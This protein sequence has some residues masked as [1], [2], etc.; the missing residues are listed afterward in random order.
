MAE[1]D[2]YSG[3]YT[4]LPN[5]YNS[6]PEPHTA[7]PP[8]PPPPPPPLP[9][10]PA[11]IPQTQ[12]NSATYVVQVPKD[13]IYR[14]PTPENAAFAERRRL[15]PT[16]GGGKTIRPCVSGC[17]CVWIFLLVLIAIALALGVSVF[18]LYFRPKNPNFNILG[19]EI[20]T[21][22]DNWSST[23][24]SRHQSKEG[25]KIRLRSENSN[26][27]ADVWYEE[28]G[29]ASLSVGQPQRLETVG[30]GTYPTFYNLH[31]ETTPFDVVL[32]GSDE[33]VDR[34]RNNKQLMIKSGKSK[35]EVKL[36]LKMK[37]T[38]RTEV[39]TW[40][41]GSMKLHVACNVVLDS[42]AKGTRTIMSED[43]RTLREA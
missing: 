25:F 36:Y 13:Q 31:G 9:L 3:N 39:W 32:R 12:S 23:R 10:P 17:C 40:K 4:C 11:Y 6:Q 21:G 33:S 43:C 15:N 19:F 8:P 2:P 30:V 20:T 29:T 34:V 26:E 28:G 1:R 18:S 22:V 16:V 14:V 42:F 37:V 35:G 24:Y 27:K 7:P 41:T 38:A 5:P